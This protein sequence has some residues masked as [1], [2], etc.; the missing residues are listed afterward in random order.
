MPAPR[1]TKWQ[2]DIQVTAANV[3]A[4]GRASLSQYA[5]SAGELRDYRHIRT[6]VSITMR[7]SAA[8]ATGYFG[9][10]K[11]DQDIVPTTTSDLEFGD[12][13]I[14]HVIPWAMTGDVTPVRFNMNWPQVK[15]DEYTHWGVFINVST[16]SAGS[17]DYASSQSSMLYE[18]SK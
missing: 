13:A 9:W 10:Y 8:Q 15:V 18:R 7:T 2:N 4:T 5:P 1:T 6:S 12:T 3:S 14:F 17:L 16:I 11:T